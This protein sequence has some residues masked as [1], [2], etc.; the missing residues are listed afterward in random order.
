MVRWWCTDQLFRVGNP[1][2]KVGKLGGCARLANQAFPK[3]DCHDRYFQDDFGYDD[4]DYDYGTHDSN[5]ELFID[6]SQT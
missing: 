2:Q 6:I 1:C 4:Y 3:D 5:Q